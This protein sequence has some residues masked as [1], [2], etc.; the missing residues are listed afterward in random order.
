ML[1]PSRVPIATAA[2]VRS[3]SGC[4]SGRAIWTTALELSAE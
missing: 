1:R 3:A 2:P 4:I